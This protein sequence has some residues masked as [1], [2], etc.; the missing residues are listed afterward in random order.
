MKKLKITLAALL[1]LCFTFGT[2]LAIPP[3]PP[4]PAGGLTNVTDCGKYANLQAC[5]DAAGAGG[6][7]YIPPGTYT[8]GIVLTSAHAGVTITGAGYGSYIHVAT[9][10]G[11]SATGGSGTE[12]KNIKISN[13]RILTDDVAGFGVS[14]TYVND[15]LFEKLYFNG[16]K[17]CSIKLATSNGNNIKDSV[18]TNGTT[19]SE[20]AGDPREIW[21]LLSNNNIISTCIF[22]DS[23]RGGIYLNGGA[24]NSALFNTFKTIGSVAIYT[25]SD[26]YDTIQGNN[27]NTISGSGYGIYL[28]G[29]G[30]SVT[31]N[32][33]RACSCGIY[34]VTLQGAVITANYLYNNA[35]H[36]TLV[37]NSTGN[38]VRDNYLDPPGTVVDSGHDNSV[39]IAGNLVT[40]ATGTAAGVTANSNII[41]GNGMNYFTNVLPGD[42]VTIFNAG[43]AGQLYSGFFRVLSVTDANNIVVD[44]TFKGTQANYLL[45]NIYRRASIINNEG[46]LRLA[47][48]G[49]LEGGHRLRENIIAAAV[50]SGSI[51]TI[52]SAPTAG[53]TGYAQNDLV[54][55]TTGSSDAIVKV[56]TV[57]GTGG[58]VV[59]TVGL[60]DSGS[61]GYTVATG[62]ATLK[63]T[64]AGTGLTVNITAVGLSVAQVSDTII[65]NTGQA[66]ADITNYLPIAKA[67]YKFSALLSVTQTGKKWQLANNSGILNNASG[68]VM[69]LAGVDGTAGSTHG[70]KDTTATKGDRLDCWTACIDATNGYYQWFCT[71]GTTTGIWAAY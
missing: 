47:Q 54:Y 65:T 20:V 12:L 39:F 25:G 36:I 48:N 49:Y 66:S 5:V 44:Y 19:G 8:S 18:F 45:F 33:V 52:N 37:A 70:I 41:N 6:Y 4:S 30:Y 24:H 35:S 58:S 56:L 9:G 53:G 14:G 16:S 17:N 11:I 61:Y 15:S 71:A 7:A 69:A 2:A 43:T 57:G 21:L 34:G 27:I 28:D 22:H 63:I 51:A 62:Q 60:V 26:N 67:G 46:S 32:I 50:A 31:G 10:H 1:I 38:I 68:D 42:I 23:N 29:G 64:G 13:L 55:V 59:Q 40:I 3:M